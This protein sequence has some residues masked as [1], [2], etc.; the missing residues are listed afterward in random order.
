[1]PGH[2]RTQPP[3]SNTDN[4]AR[5]SERGTEAE[6]AV[7]HKTGASQLVTTGPYRY[8]RNP[9]YVSLTLLQLA[10]DL[11]AQVEQDETLAQPVPVVFNLST[12]RKGQ[13]LIEWLVIELSTKY[14]IPKRI[15]RPWL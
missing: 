9:M 4:P 7:P 10:R 6:T 5:A 13:P 8:S 15:G 2:C 11:I 3:S 12:W 1:M 14:Q